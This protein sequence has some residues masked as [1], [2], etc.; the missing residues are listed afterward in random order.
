LSEIWQIRE[1]ENINIEGFKI[2]GLE[3]RENRKGGLTL[4]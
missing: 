4:I 2:A 3:Q 1:Y